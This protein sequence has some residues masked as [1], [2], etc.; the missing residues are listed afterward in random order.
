MMQ[1]LLTRLD[2]VIDNL[3]WLLLVWENEF[4]SIGTKLGSVFEAILATYLKIDFR[5]N[6][7]NDH[8]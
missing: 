3:L 8:F 1:W 7:C 6:Q 5:D 2:H 4:Y